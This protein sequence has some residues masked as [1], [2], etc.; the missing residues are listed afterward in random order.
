MGE[1]VLVPGKLNLSAALIFR[2]SGAQGA[3]KEMAFEAGM[4]K[5]GGDERD[6]YR[7]QETFSLEEP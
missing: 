3:A 2:T 4:K 1:I 5:P 6:T 7:L